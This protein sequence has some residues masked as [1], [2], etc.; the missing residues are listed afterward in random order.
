MQSDAF[1]DSLEFVNY[2]K[3]KAQNFRALAIAMKSPLILDS[4]SKSSEP[5]NES[6]NL[7]PFNINEN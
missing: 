4:R 7:L 1:Q 5:K 6:G 2:I 3:Q